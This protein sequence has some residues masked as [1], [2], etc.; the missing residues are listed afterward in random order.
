[1]FETFVMEDPPTE[2]QYT[3]DF[4]AFCRIGEEPFTAN[5]FISFAP[6]DRLLEFESFEKWLREEMLRE[7]ITIEEAAKRIFDALSAAL[8]DIPLQVTV[9]ART[10]VH[11]SVMAHYSN[12]KWRQRCVSTLG[13]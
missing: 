2:I 5:A 3:P 10:T 13:E 11:A 8:G 1:M 7:P 6:T 9:D 4:D 12:E